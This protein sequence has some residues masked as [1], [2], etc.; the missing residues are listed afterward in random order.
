[1][2]RS[3]PRNPVYPA[4][5]NTL[6]DEAFVQ[7]AKELPLYSDQFKRPSW[8]KM[9]PKLIKQA[10]RRKVRNLLR[11]YGVI[12]VIAFV[13]L[14]AVLLTPPIG[15]QAFSPIYQELRSWGNGMSQIVFGNG[16]QGEETAVAAGSLDD[17]KADPMGTSCPKVFPMSV[18]MQLKDISS[19]LPFKLPKMTYLPHGFRFHSAELIP[20]SSLTTLSDE[21]ITADGVYLLFET[22]SGKQLTLTYKILEKNE[23]I[24]MPYEEHIEA[25]KLDNGTIAYY[26]PDSIAQITFLIG[27]VY[28]MAAGQLDK[29][30]LLQIANGLKKRSR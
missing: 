18:K 17:H 14:S 23:M 22:D 12:A 11:R 27:D 1:M 16:R 21:N 5:L 13:L 15:T 9:Q 8:S 10:R 2:K 29:S 4:E 25:V 24:R 26:T 7:A 3:S 6:I 20:S 19:R 28:F 30:E